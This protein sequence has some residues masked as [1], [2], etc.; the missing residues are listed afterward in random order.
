MFLG[1]DA[2]DWLIFA[3][4]QARSKRELD[5]Q[6]RSEFTIPPRN[7]GRRHV[8]DA[9]C[10]RSSLACGR[11]DF[12]ARRSFQEPGAPVLGIKIQAA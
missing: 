1:S 2:S 3:K 10:G 7:A 11:R 9:R 5:L 4:N 12:G 8:L 6:D